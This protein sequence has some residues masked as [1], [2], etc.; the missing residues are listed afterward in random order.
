MRIAVPTNDGKTISEHFGR[1]AA[2]L[3]FEIENG[4]IKNR[5]MRTNA[6][7]HADDGRTCGHSAAGSEPHRHAGILSTLTGCETVICTGM[8]WR[9]A[10]ALKS[11]GISPV[12]ASAPEPVEDAMAAYLKGELAAGPE[13]YCRCQH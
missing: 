3:V 5:E 9:A 12:V 11:A 1:S 7:Q 6:G 4:Q 13:E 8:G 10:E 2:F